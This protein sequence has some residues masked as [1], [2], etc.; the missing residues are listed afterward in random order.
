MP[1][2]APRVMRTTAAATRRWA[3]VCFRSP[4][5][6]DTATQD[7]SDGELF[8]IIEYGVRFTGMAAWGDGS[9]IGEELGWKLVAFIRQ[10]PNLTTQDLEE[11]KELNP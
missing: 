3:R 8:Y 2:T 11:M 1:A 4:R 10:L 5:T 9:Q 6:C 7:L